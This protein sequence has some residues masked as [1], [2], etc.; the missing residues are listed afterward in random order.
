MLQP[1]QNM[2]LLQETEELKTVG[3]YKN[4]RAPLSTGKN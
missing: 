2:D 3:W 4:T 1:S